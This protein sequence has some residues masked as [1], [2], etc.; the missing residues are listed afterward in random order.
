MNNPAAPLTPASQ[1]ALAEAALVLEHAQGFV[2]VPVLVQSERAGALAMEVLRPAL[3][4]ELFRVPWP[5]PQPHTDDPEEAQRRVQA[6]LQAVVSALDGATRRLPAGAVLLLDMSSRT[7]QAVAHSLIVLLNQRREDW[8]RNGQ[9]LLLLWPQSESEALMQ[10]APDLWSA[11]AV[12][13]WVEE[14]DTVAHSVQSVPWQFTPPTSGGGAELSPAQQ[15]QFQA[16]QGAHR[17]HEADMSAADVLALVVALRKVHQ[18]SAALALTERM[19]HTP[20]FGLQTLDWQA[21]MFTELV[22][23]RRETGDRQGALAPALEAVN[24]YRHLAQVNS[25]AYEPKLAASLNNLATC[26]SETGDRAG[27]LASAQQAETIHSRLV[28]ANPAAYE[29]DLAGSLNNLATCLGDTGGRVG[30]LAPAH[31]AVTIRRRLAQAN[32]LAYEPDLATSLN[33]LANRLSEAGDRVGA[34]AL[35]QEAVSIRRHLAQVNPAA[36]ETDL[37][38]SLNTLTN[39]LSEAGDRAGALAPAHEAV[40]IYR[41]LALANPGAYEPDLAMSLNNL[42]NRL[43]ETGDHAGAL[44]PAQEAVEIRRR[45]AQD[46]PVAYEPNLAR[47]LN[48]LSNRLRKTGDRVGALTMVQEALNIRR[49]LAQSS[50][51][52]YERDL[53]VSLWTAMR[54]F[55]SANQQQPAL[56]HGREAL[57]LFTRLAEREPACFQPYLRKV[58]AELHQLEQS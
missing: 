27:A 54:C 33:N 14:Q 56:T 43:S 23:L 9:G 28:Q 42:S 1:Q 20:D 10:G 47:S 46:N 44:A 16:L 24:I 38:R 12:S 45:L 57:Q 3:K 52:A 6:D 34:L 32:P 36:Y 17:W 48:A 58:Q 31:E 40:S 41:S 22:L 15:R 18:A 21:S 53:A 4:A 49:R 30:A 39:R 13:P 2:Y 7:R 8:R 55:A 11:R 35:A 19:L 26:L 5:L 29:P 25:A 50:P 37:A 51:A